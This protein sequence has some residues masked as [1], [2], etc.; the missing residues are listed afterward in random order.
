MFKMCIPQ[1]TTKNYS[2]SSHIRKNTFIQN[3][4][5]NSK[6]NLIKNQSVR[7]NKTI[8]LN[9]IIDSAANAAASKK[10]YEIFT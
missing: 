6:I 3:D 1:R 2:S 7:R 9:S 4:E 8:E 10:P 5:E